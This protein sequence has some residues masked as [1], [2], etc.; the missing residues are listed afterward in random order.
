MLQ[1]YGTSGRFLSDQQEKIGQQE[2]S[3]G[4][5][6]LSKQYLGYFQN[7]LWMPM[8]RDISQTKLS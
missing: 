8:S 6:P 7:L 4:A 3:D 1:Q 2:Y 5:D